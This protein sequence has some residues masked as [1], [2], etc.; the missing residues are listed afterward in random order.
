MTKKNNL[1]DKVREMAKSQMFEVS[2]S[3]IKD[4]E[5][6]FEEHLKRIAKLNKIDVTGIEPQV[7]PDETFRTYL[8][9]DVVNNDTHISRENLLSNAPRTKYD[10]VAIPRA[11]KDD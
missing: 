2:P 9:P 4:F 11:V 8:R 3:V 7:Y 10:E 5:E 6:F 1:H